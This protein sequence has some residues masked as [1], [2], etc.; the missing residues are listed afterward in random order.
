[1]GNQERQWPVCSRKSCGDSASDGEALY[2]N[3]PEVAPQGSTSNGHRN[4]SNTYR[5]PPPS[6]L[7]SKTDAFFVAAGLWDRNNNWLP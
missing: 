2:N 4:A 3:S 7:L 5:N 1:M 6:G